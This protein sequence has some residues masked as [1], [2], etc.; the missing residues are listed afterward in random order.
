MQ[1][2]IEQFNDIIDSYSI[3]ENE[4]ID[5][6]FKFKAI[7][8]FKDFSRLDAR[9]FYF[10]NRRSYSFHWMK[11]DNTLIMRRDNANHYPEMETF[12]FHKHVREKENVQDSLEVTLF[13]VLTE[14]KNIFKK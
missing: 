11:E 9:D 1:E 5:S 13:D 6:G 10:P 7:I 8:R 3:L 12:P 2:I 4:I 14:I